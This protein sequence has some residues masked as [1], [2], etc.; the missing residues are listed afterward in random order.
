MLSFIKKI[1]QAGTWKKLGIMRKRFVH[2]HR[3]DRRFVRSAKHSMIVLIRH[4][5]KTKIAC[6]CL[7]CLFARKLL[8][9]VWEY[10]YLLEP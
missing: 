2:F 7:E 9:I 3:E 8:H 1:V 10:R 6:Q 4:S 5:Y